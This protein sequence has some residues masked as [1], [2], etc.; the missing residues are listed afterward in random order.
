V[1]ETMESN[2]P[3][4]PSTMSVGELAK[5]IASRDPEAC[6]HQALLMVDNEGLLQG[7]ITRGDILRAIDREPSGSSSVLESGSS[8][9]VVTYPDETLSDATDKMLRYD[10]GRLPVVERA[11]PKQIVGYLGRRNV[12]A[13]RLR[14]MEDEQVREKGWLG[15]SIAT[16]K[17]VSA[18]PKREAYCGS[19]S[20]RSLII[21]WS[22]AT[23]HGDKRPARPTCSTAERK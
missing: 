20:S 18:E 12:M 21:R 5:R 23:G 1:A 16:E 22:N 19:K 6:R 2:P 15:S 3:T 8:K 13:A 4:V 14:R 9:L 7:I 11:N 10:I 17:N